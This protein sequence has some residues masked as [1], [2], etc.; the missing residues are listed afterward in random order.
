MLGDRSHLCGRRALD[1]LSHRVG[2]LREPLE[3]E[4]GHTRGSADREQQDARAQPLPAPQGYEE[5]DDRMCDGDDVGRYGADAAHERGA[6]A[7]RTQRRVDYRRQGQQI[8]GRKERVHARVARLLDVEGCEAEQQSGDE[9]QAW[10]EEGPR[11]LLAH[12]LVDDIVANPNHHCLEHVLEFSPRHR[13]RL[14]NPRESV[15]DREEQETEENL[16]KD[17]IRETLDDDGRVLVQDRDR[18]GSRVG[19]LGALGLGVPKVGLLIEVAEDL[20]EVD[21]ARR[22]ISRN[23]R[24]TRRTGHGGSLI[25]SRECEQELEPQDD[26]RDQHPRVLLAA[27]SLKPCRA[28]D[29]RA[30]TTQANT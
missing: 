21:R 6:R 15:E 22:R 13:A 9:S 27:S 10:P 26:G 16:D 23:A 18:L 12:G 28:L 3:E 19:S 25:R 8:E 5:W 30:S 7:L 24:I 11:D 29:P 2:P 1:G 14:A 17:V 20:H 4:E